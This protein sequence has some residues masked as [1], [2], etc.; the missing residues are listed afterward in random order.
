MSYPPSDRD[1]VNEWV[2]E[3]TL[4]KPRAR[5]KDTHRYQMMLYHMENSRVRGLQLFHVNQVI[6]TRGNCLESNVASKLL[7]GLPSHDVGVKS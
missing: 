4:K 5:K 2:E 7:E 1:G 3:L 6:E